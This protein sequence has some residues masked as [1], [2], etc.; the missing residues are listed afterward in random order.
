MKESAVKIGLQ[1]EEEIDIKLNGTKLI[2]GS[3]QCIE[4]SH[5]LL[6]KNGSLNLDSSETA[7]ISGLD[8][9]YTSKKIATYPYA[10][11]HF[12]IEDLLK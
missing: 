12:T 6:L 8:S 11:P 7:S 9:Y 2:I 4:L 3:I 1:F 5:K 10:R